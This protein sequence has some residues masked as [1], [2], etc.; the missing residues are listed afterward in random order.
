MISGFSDMSLSPNTIYFHLWRPR[1][2]SNIQRK[3]R[4]SLSKNMFANFKMLAIQPFHF[5]R[6]DGGPKHPVD[7]SNKFLKILH[8]GPRSSWKHEMNIW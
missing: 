7:P 8:M 6:Q 3:L 4:N 2:T 5:V 1:A